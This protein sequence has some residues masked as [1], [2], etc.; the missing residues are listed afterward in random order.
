MEEKFGLCV[1]WDHFDFLNHNQ[2]L[3]VDSHSQ[4]RQRAHGNLLRQRPALVNWKILSFY[5]VTRGLIKQ[6]S[7]WR[8]YLNEVGLFFTIQHIIQTLRQFISIIFAFTKILKK[9]WRK[10]VQQ[11]SWVEK[12]V[13]LNWEESIRYLLNGKRWFKKWH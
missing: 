4:Q 2:T 3:N 7:H 6:K 13:D 10:H 11:T 9:I 12:Q 8:K 1:W 5:L